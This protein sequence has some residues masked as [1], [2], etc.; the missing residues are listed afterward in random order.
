MSIISSVLGTLA[1]VA[2]AGV[3]GW[4]LGKAQPTQSYVYNIE[5][6]NIEH[7]NEEPTQQETGFL[8]DLE[9][10]IPM[11]FLML[12]LPG[13]LGNM[14]NRGGPSGGGDIIIVEDD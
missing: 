9:G 4:G 12:M 2:A 13:F 10:M 14:G 8:G 1:P 6:M 7:M 11:L 5:A 3:A